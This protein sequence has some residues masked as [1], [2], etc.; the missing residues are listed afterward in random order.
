M[1]LADNKGCNR[2]FLSEKQGS[3]KTRHPLKMF[4]PTNFRCI[5]KNGAFFNGGFCKHQVTFCTFYGFIFI[6]THK[7]CQKSAQSQSRL[8]NCAVTNC[9]LSIQISK[10]WYCCY[11]HRTSIT[12]HKCLPN[13]WWHIT[14]YSLCSHI[15]SLVPYF[16]CVA[17]GLNE[18]FSLWIKLVC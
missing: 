12:L 10:K 3:G 6:W 13:I 15:C 9:L 1:F 11:S 14:L 8:Y 2:F 4:F 17:K 16:S 5:T 18:V 7:N